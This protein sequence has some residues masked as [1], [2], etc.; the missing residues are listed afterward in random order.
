MPRVKVADHEPPPLSGSFLV[1]LCFSMVGLWIY[2]AHHQI[3]DFSFDSGFPTESTVN[4]CRDFQFLIVMLQE[5]REDGRRWARGVSPFL[6][7]GVKFRVIALKAHS[8]WVCEGMVLL[9]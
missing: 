1:V 7:R 2:V 5:K 3:L 4:P 6:Q 8:C 9:T